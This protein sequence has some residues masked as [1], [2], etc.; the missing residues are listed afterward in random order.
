MI[1]VGTGLQQCRIHVAIYSVSMSVF[2]GAHTAAT[3]S[4]MNLMPAASKARRA[5]ELL[6]CY[7]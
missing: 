3:I 2:E 6:G 7:H 5:T 1:A 4:S